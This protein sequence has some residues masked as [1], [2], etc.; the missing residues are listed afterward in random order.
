MLRVRDPQ[1]ESERQI[2]HVQTWREIA[3]VLEEVSIPE[4]HFEAAVVAS[5]HLAPAEERARVMK[6]KRTIILAS[7]RRVDVSL[8]TT[9]QTSVRQYPFNATDSL[10]LIGGRQVVGKKAPAAKKPVRKKKK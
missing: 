7:N 2:E 1:I 3:G 6:N 8:N 4:P 9:G 5:D 10:T